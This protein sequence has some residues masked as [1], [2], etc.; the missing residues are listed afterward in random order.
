MQFIVLDIA[1]GTFAF[2]PDP[3]VDTNSFERANYTIRTLNLNRDVLIRARKEAFDSY[4]FRLRGFIAQRDSGSQIGVL[5]AL[6]KSLTGMQHP[7]VWREM[8]RQSPKILLLNELF[9]QAPEAMNW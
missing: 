5:K 3:E 6:I 2:C 9:N 4:V 8:R 1:G 7:T